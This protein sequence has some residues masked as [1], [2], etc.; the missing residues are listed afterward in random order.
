MTID[1][2]K[3]QVNLTAEELYN[4]LADVKNFEKLMPENTSKFEILGD[5]KFLFAL[6]GMPEIVLV[7]KEKQ[8]NDKI[9]LGAA[10]D[11]LPFTLTADISETG[12]NSSE[13]SLTFHGE[14]NAMMGM[15]IKG[16]ITT[17]I[18]TLT[19]NMAKL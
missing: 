13:A 17:F 15:M 2:P 10:S 6:S 12:E 19:A 18:N 1:T 3:T 7:I 4:F 11:K 8:P 16:P 14:F 9:V 5:E